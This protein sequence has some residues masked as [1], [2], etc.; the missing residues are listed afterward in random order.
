MIRPITFVMITYQSRGGTFQMRVSE[1]HVTPAM[2][3][4]ESI[5]GVIISAHA[6]V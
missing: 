5:G 2:E 3:D 1:G 6:E 4:I